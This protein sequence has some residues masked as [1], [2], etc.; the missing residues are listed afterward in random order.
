M[1]ANLK[2]RFGIED[3]SVSYSL[4][5]HNDTYNDDLKLQS[6]PHVSLPKELISQLKDIP[7]DNLSDKFGGVQLF[8][9]NYELM[10]GM[11]LLPFIHNMKNSS[12]RL[13][14][15]GLGCDGEKKVPKSLN[16]WKK[17]F[18]NNRV[19]MYF[20]EFDENCVEEMKSRGFLEND[21][22]FHVNIL[23][24]SENIFFM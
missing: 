10:Y 12:I 9:H 2:S 23:K 14:E 3:K 13:L 6:I 4:F 8:A 16:V 15:V 22:N 20:A 19:D 24:G 17:L 21:E 7:L 11:F 1:K 5:N 18:H